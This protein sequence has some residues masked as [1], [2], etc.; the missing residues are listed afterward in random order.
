M[1]ATIKFEIETK[2]KEVML[3]MYQ[4]ALE[5]E[6]TGMTDKGQ[7]LEQMS[8]KLDALGNLAFKHGQAAK[9]E[10]DIFNS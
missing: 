5:S 3:K 10:C 1:K 4:T 6:K 9:L 7:L 8:E 2:D